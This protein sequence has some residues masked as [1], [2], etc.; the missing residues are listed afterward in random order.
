MPKTK[1]FFS[2]QTHD[3]SLQFTKLDGFTQFRYAMMKACGVCQLF[4]F[5]RYD[6]CFF[7]RKVDV[8]TLIAVMKNGLDAIKFNFE[9]MFCQYGWI[10]LDFWSRR[11]FTYGRLLS[12]QR[13]EE[14]EPGQVYDLNANFSV[15]KPKRKLSL[16]SEIKITGGI[17]LILRTMWENYAIPA[18][19]GD[20]HKIEQMPYRPNDDET[21]S[22]ARYIDREQEWTIPKLKGAV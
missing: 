11:E 2:T 9:V 13:L 6:R 4:D 15:Q 12:T 3:Y 1:T 22:L 8:D 19:E 21:V 16:K 14:L 17:E 5:M 18:T 10:R 20:A 7:A